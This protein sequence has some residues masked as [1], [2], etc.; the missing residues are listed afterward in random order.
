[1]KLPWLGES[2]DNTNLDGD[3]KDLFFHPYLGKWSNLTNIFQMGWHHQLEIY[4]NFEEMFY[5]SALLWPP[6]D[7][8]THGFYKVHQKVIACQH[9]VQTFPKWTPKKL[10]KIPSKMKAFKSSVLVGVS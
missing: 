5:K 3:F 9:V 6:L 10:E 4:G 2:N 1:M 8:G 7:I